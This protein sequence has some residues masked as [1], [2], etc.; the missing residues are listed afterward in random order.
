MPA[1]AVLTGPLPKAGVVVVA[2]LAATALLVQDPRGRARAMA[3][4]VALAPVLLVAEI[5]NTP[6]LGFVHRHPLPALVGAILGVACILALAMVMTRRPA[7][8][9]VLAVAALPFRVPIGTAG[10]TANLLVPL[11]LVV[12][13]GAVAMIWQGLRTR[14]GKRPRDPL[15]PESTL[16]PRTARAR[17]AALPSVSG[18]SK[19]GS[20]GW[21]ERL[22]ALY[23]VLY[24]MQAI[25]SPSFETALQNMVFFYVPFT[26]LYVLLS[27]LE[28]TPRLLRLCFTVIVALALAFAGIGFVEYATKSIFLNSKLIISNDLHTYF[29]VNSVFFDPDIFGRFL[30]IVMIGL[31]TVLLFGRRPREQLGVTACL[32]VLWGGLLLTLSRSSQLALLLGLGV[33][34]AFRWQVRRAVIIAAAVV[35][36]GAVAIA[37]TPS[38]FGLNQ[39]LNGASS[40]RA[41]LVTRGIHMFSQRPVWGYGSGSFVH[42]Y[43]V[44]YHGN[45]QQTTAS[46]TIAVTI[47]AEQGLIGELVY[48]ALVILAA[49]RLLGGARADPAR[50][51][52]GAAFI[53]LLF[54]TLLYADFLEDPVTW[55]LI[56]VGTALAR[57]SSRRR[58]VPA[59]ERARA[60]ASA[61]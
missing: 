16:V 27:E 8:F 41:N 52:V 58:E 56:A 33:V 54:H 38:T 15:V 18:E 43:Q 44:H 31:A 47:A 42:E 55:A 5:W 21:V 3:G 14:A 46:H 29:T 6:Q 26:L 12:A 9:P 49:V 1:F 13:A 51:A 24:A 10:R 2:A 25:Y 61:A 36:L 20:A 40:G 35:A 48:L 4:A 32:A 11:Y 53:A 50:V 30:M 60:R 7:V 34:A 39:G 23:L 45:A 28:W 19:P 57:A 22:L 59:R 37:I 17:A